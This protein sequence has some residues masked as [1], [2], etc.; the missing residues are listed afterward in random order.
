M[1]EIILTFQ[2]QLSGVMET[3]F[4]AAIFEITRLVE[5]SFLEEVS[6]NR[7]QVE[8]LKKRLQWSETRRKDQEE[9]RRQKCADCGKAR[10]SDGERKQE[11]ALASQTGVEHAQNLKQERGS[12]ESWES[13]EAEKKDELSGLVES[14][15]VSS[16]VKAAKTAAE[17]ERRLN[18]V[19]KTEAVH[20]VTGAKPQEGWSLATEVESSDNSGHSKSYSEQELQQIQDDWSSGLTHET[21]PEPESYRTRYNM[22]DL[23]TASY[24]GHEL[25]MGDL[26]GLTVSPHRTGEVLGFGALSGSLQTDLST[27][28]ECGRRIRSKRGNKSSS[29][30]HNPPDTGDLNCLLINEEG[31]LQDINAISQA[32]SGLVGDP[33]H[34]GHSMYSR[35]TVNDSSNCFYSGDAFSQSVDLNHTEPVEIVGEKQPHTC[36]QCMISFPD[37]V[38]LKTHMLTHRASTSPSYVCNQ[39]G[40]KFTQACNLKVHQR[41]HQRDGLHLC[42]HCGKGYSSFSDLRRHRCSQAGDKPYSCSLCGNKFSRLWNLKLHR[43][44]HTQEKPHQCSMCD[45]S[46][47]R[48]DI[49]KVHQ[50]THTGERPYCCRTQLSGVMETILRS[51]VCEVTRLVEGSFLEEVDRGKREAEVLRR[52]LQILETKLGERERV[53]RVK[54][55]DCGKTGFSKKETEGRDCRTQAGVELVGVMKHEG[56]SDGGRNGGKGAVAP[57]QEA[58]STIPDAELK[59]VEINEARVGGAVKEEVTESADTQIYSTVHSHTADHRET[60][61]HNIGEMS[62]LHASQ[63]DHRGPQ[64][65][66]LP[67]SKPCSPG[68]QDSVKNRPHLQRPDSKTEHAVQSPLPQQGPATV[69]S[70]E[71]SPVKQLSKTPNSLPIKQEVIVV[72]PP[73][74]EEVDRVRSSTVSAPSKANPARDKHQHIDPPP[75]RPPLEASVM[76][77][78]PCGKVS[79]PASQVTQ[80]RTSVKK[81]TKLTEHPS[82]LA[83]SPGT[84]NVARTQPV[85]KNP[86]SVPKPSQAL[87][88]LQRAYAD[89][90]SISALQ[91][92]RNLMQA[93]SARTGGHIGHHAVRTPH[94]CSQCGKGFSHLCHLRAHQQIH[95]GLESKIQILCPVSTKAVQHNNERKMS[96]TLIVTFQSQLSV[97][98]ETILKSAMFEITKLVEDSFVEEVGHAK[99]EVELL[100]RRLQFYESKLKDRE[101]TVRCVDC[102]KATGNSERTAE[103]S[104]EALSGA[105]TLCFSLSLREQSGKRPPLSEVWRPAEILDSHTPTETH[106]QTQKKA[107]ALEQSGKQDPTSNATV[108]IHQQVLQKFLP[109]AAVTGIHEHCASSKPRESQ[110]KTPGIDFTPSKEIDLTQSRL[111]QSSAEEDE[112]GELASSPPCPAVKSEHEP[113]PVAIKEEEEMLPVWDCTDDSVPVESDLNHTDFGGSWNREETQVDNFPNLTT[114]NMSDPTSYLMSLSEKCNPEMSQGIKAE[115][116]QSV[117]FVLAPIPE[118]SGSRE[119]IESGHLRSSNRESF[120]EG[121]A[122][123]QELCPGEKVYLLVPPPDHFPRNEHLHMHENLHAEKPHSCIHCGKSFAQ[124]GHLKVHMLTHKGRKPL[125]C[126][127]CNKTFVHNFEL[128]VHQRQ[129]SGERPHVCPHCGKGFTRLSNFKQHQNI[130]TREKLFNCTHCGMR[131]NRSTHLRVHLRRHTRAGKSSEPKNSS[132]PSHRPGPGTPHEQTE[133]V[134]CKCWFCSVVAREILT[135]FQVW[136]RAC[137]SR[138]IEWGP[139]TAKII[140]ALPYLSGRETEVIVRCTKMLHNR[141]DYLRRRAKDA[142]LERNAFPVA[143][144]YL[145]QLQRGD[146]IPHMNL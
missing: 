5:D 43:R 81:P 93:L 30:L 24:S 84:T 1:S 138:N 17:E 116:S 108:Q 127:Q 80:Q 83:S 95:T 48:A 113:D 23:G 47:T 22:E 131:F 38:S 119:Q 29:S 16:P 143:Q 76:Y 91:P 20:T 21:D 50:R 114:L 4:K 26:N 146:I 75:S 13:C 133:N 61:V 33:G 11:K 112:G 49:L 72:L 2:S 65:D 97:I 63:P 124:V 115:P 27:P 136:Q 19:P 129:H 52:R 85:N 15:D 45:K 46:F 92:G 78:G 51:A 109:S 132:T 134:Q 130:H 82:V 34:R 98:M 68:I 86:A 35:D 41:I 89:E 144:R 117:H 7:E 145:V 67:G 59:I 125:S 66:K 79:T 64:R 90:R 123:P 69:P 103:P 44:I 9:G 54:C 118:T 28:A 73:E 71:C 36:S 74:W 58:S 99:Q 141:R 120:R 102:G 32:P 94:N 55:V 122:V 39:C 6:R 14:D 126:P 139:I 104:A 42:S 37:Q 31:Y 18:C 142:F 8:S 10:L 53:K 40:K 70:S 106:A 105:D 77:P 62:G 25:D 96:D 3:V 60:Q 110:H 128:K 101:R 137:Y 87:Q 12:E 57:G 121:L 100:M 107:E 56:S 140:S 111:T 88:H 135:Q